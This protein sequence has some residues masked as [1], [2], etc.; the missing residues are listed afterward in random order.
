MRVRGETDTL[1]PCEQDVLYTMFSSQKYIIVLLIYHGITLYG[2]SLVIGY[3][4]RIKRYVLP[5]R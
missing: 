3:N 1:S 4:I 2:L 5:K